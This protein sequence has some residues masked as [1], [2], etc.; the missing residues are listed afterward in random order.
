[1]MSSSTSNQRLVS[2]IMNKSRYR[3]EFVEFLQ[4]EKKSR[5]WYGWVMPSDY[6][7]KIGTRLKN[8]TK[9]DWLAIE[10]EKLRSGLYELK[11]QEKG[12]PKIF[13]DARKQNQSNNNNN[14]NKK[15]EIICI[16][17]D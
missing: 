5:Q 16:D 13:L 7:R 2:T 17:D 11:E 15:N 14:S 6:F 10:R 12:E 8:E 3:S 9:I 4:L 1:L